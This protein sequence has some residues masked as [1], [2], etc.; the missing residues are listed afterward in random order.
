M[1][2]IGRKQEGSYC[3]DNLGGRRA[4]QFYSQLDVC[5]MTLPDR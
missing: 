5:R 1:N 4:H 3:R 2:K